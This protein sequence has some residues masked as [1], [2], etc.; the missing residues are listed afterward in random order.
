MHELRRS[1]SRRPKEIGKVRVAQVADRQAGRV[2]AFQL[3]HLGVADS[4]VHGWVR[5]GYLFRVAPR[6]YA[7]GHVA[8]SR[9]ADLW[10]A[11]LYAAPARRSVT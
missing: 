8:P 2:A 7:V 11:V 3:T 4:T 6:V 10:T 5:S 9:E 1:P